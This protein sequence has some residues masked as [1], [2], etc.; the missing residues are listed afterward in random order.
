MP[1]PRLWQVQRSDAPRHGLQAHAQASIIVAGTDTGDCMLF[2][3]RTGQQAWTAACGSQVNG[4]ALLPTG[5]VQ[6]VVTA[7]EDG[8]LRLL[9]TR[10]QASSAELA[11][12]QLQQRVTDVITDGAHAITCEM[13]TGLI[14]W[15]LDPSSGGTQECSDE[16]VISAAGAGVAQQA[17]LPAFGDVTCLAAGACHLPCPQV[18]AGHA[19]G[20]VSILGIEL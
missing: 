14:I 16:A 18:V 19:V 11:S 3:A 9:D 17:R 4:L 13:G 6:S 7:H 5:D 1:L 12:V 2:D 15:H 20:S 10:R 8:S